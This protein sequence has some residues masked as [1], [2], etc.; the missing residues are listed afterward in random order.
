MA[1][2]NAL[3]RFLAGAPNLSRDDVEDV[4][5]VLIILSGAPVDD[6]RELAVVTAFGARAGIDGDAPEQLGA[7]IAAYFESRASI[8]LVSALIQLVRE[9]AAS[10]ALDAHAI[11]A[12]IGRAAGVTG[13]LGGGT[14]PEGTVPA[15]PAARFA[16]A[17]KLPPKP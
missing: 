2:E 8:A 16:A 5:A 11:G 10:G 1:L 4:T 14:R 7:R 6:A 12:V 9:D 17:K 15:G 13:V 3:A